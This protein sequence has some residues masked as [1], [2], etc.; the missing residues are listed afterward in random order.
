MDGSG[1]N[2]LGSMEE[3]I[4]LPAESRLTFSADSTESSVLDMEV[5]FSHL[6]EKNDPY[7]ESSATATSVESVPSLLP[8]IQSLSCIEQPTLIGPQDLSSIPRPSHLQC[9]GMEVRRSE[10]MP[11][12]ES[13][14]ESR[15][16]SLFT[17]SGTMEEDGDDVDDFLLPGGLAAGVQY[18][19]KRI[20]AE[21]WL[22][23]KGTGKDYLR[24][25][26]WKTRW[27]RLVLATLD[28]EDIDV[29][30]LLVYWYH[31]SESPSTVIALDSTV[32]LSLDLEG[33]D[34]WS[35][36]RFEIRHATSKENNTLPVTRVFAASKKCR[37]AWVYVISQALLE[38]EKQKAKHRMQKKAEGKLNLPSPRSGRKSLSIE[39]LTDDRFP[40]PRLSPPL[41]PPSSPPAI[42]HHVT[43]QSP[44]RSRSL[45]PV[46]RSPLRPQSR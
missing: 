3:D 43:P 7:P 17:D 28:G 46:P 18:T 42:R 22:H 32:I 40:H 12:A 4:L 35:T 15:T 33:K 2:H 38:Y 19:P 1:C 13:R 21:G 20:L 36:H 39:S 8:E 25:R 23:K 34:Q 44:P 45:P 24:S 30:L 10:E 14:D 27:T 16:R 26:G 31:A 6:E 29:P 9:I 5:L 37:D 11:T 41:S